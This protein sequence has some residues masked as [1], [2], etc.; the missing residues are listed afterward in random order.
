MTC[1]N[2]T[3]AFFAEQLLQMPGLNWP[4]LNATGL[5]GG[6]DF[7]L[8]FSMLP[9]ALMNT[10]GRGGPPGGDGQP[11]ALPSASDPNGGYTIFE[12]VER[13]L[14]LKLRA[15]KRNEKVIVIDHLESAPTE[16]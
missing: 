15:E 9:P 10:L 11:G 13:Q 4:A 2:A 3:M 16:N 8:T 1:Q 12:A 7:S 5:E 6:W 14:G